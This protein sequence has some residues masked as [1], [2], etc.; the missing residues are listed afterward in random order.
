MLYI[1]YIMLDEG[2]GVLAQEWQGAVVPE[3][4][5]RKQKGLVMEEIRESRGWLVGRVAVLATAALMGVGGLA[6][7]YTNANPPEAKP[8]I[9]RVSDADSRIYLFGTMHLLPAGTKWQTPGFTEA[10]KDAEVTVTEADAESPGAQATIMALVQQHGM[11]PPG[12]TLSGVLGEERFKRFAELAKGL[13]IPAEPLQPMRP[14][15]AMLTVSVAVIQKAGF[16]PASGVDKAVT[17]QA[18]AEGDKILH[19]ET[20]EAQIKALMSLEGPDMLSNFDLTVE[21]SADFTKQIE[22]MLVAWRTGDMKA[23]DQVMFDE[24]RAR[25]PKVFEKLL[26]ERNRNWVPQIVKW[27]A[28][29]QDY[30]VAVGAGHLTGKG[31]VIEML[32]QKGLKVERIQ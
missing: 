20:A 13:G 18:K 1:S 24:M 23:L 30:F 17:V 19:L 15:L 26:I 8:A 12:Q 31:S 7:I 27:L 28:D 32:E 5:Q 10:M 25:A 11:N 22:R 29:R 2:A 16:D 6:V 4:A 3:P 21:Q 9:W 14:W